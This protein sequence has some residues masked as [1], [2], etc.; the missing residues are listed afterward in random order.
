MPRPKSKSIIS[1]SRKYP[2]H[3]ARLLVCGC[4]VPIVTAL[5]ARAEIP[6]SANWPA[7]KVID[8]HTHVFNARDLPLTGILNA[9]GAPR[10]VAVVV[11][12][13]FLL[14]MAGEE[15]APNFEALSERVEHP[16]IHEL[17]S[18]QRNI[19]GE[20]V[21]T[22]RLDLLGQVS[23]Y[24]KVE[25]D[26]TLLAATLAKIGFPADDYLPQWAQIKS[27]TVARE[28][29]ERLK[30][31]VR[32]IG[33][34]IRQ[35]EEIVALLRG[36][37]P[38]TDLFVHHMMDMEVA[39]AD[40][41][42]TRFPDQIRAMKKLDAT[43]PGKLLH[44]VAFDPFRRSNALPWAAT[45]INN[46]GVA[47][48]KIYPP[49]GYRA[50]DNA[51]YHFPPKPIGLLDIW[52]K[53]RW[54]ARY[55]DWTENDLDKTLQDAYAW[56]TASDV[57][58]FTH[59]TPHGFEAAKDYG[60]MSDP[61]YWA[62]ALSKKENADLALCFGH[63]GGETYWFSDPANDASHSARPP[64]D[65]WQFGHQVVEL[66]LTYP[67]V[68]CEVG[69]L[70]SILDPKKMSVLV[71]RLEAV[72][73]RPSNDGKWR[74]G[75]KLMFGTDWH[76]LYKVVGYQDYLAKWD[77]VIKSV[78]K[79]AWRQAFFAVNAKAFLRLTLLAQDPRFTPDQRRELAAL[80]AAIK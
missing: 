25:A 67:N 1:S 29:G 22:S 14:S 19:L 21:E 16:G 78:A 52:E 65:P 61:F 11:A 37:Y 15:A 44:F 58:V 47:G 30:G 77:E 5:V 7:A 70:D 38:E 42:A 74:F 10:P 64:G 73:D 51:A 80:N 3:K 9:L 49:S 20:F 39:Y 33:V 48:L 55:G 35:H 71:R 17:S 18:L 24:L 59:C 40:E 63:A 69:Y 32:F 57:P 12:E 23:T 31:Y 79:G 75:D 72:L 28:L 56:A 62:V 34:M 26:V 68:Y 53:Q 2:W 4:L 50:A 43:F 13:A 46:D 41:P 54:R 60:L 76:M 45:A 66:C 6:A 8:M 36:S 27:I